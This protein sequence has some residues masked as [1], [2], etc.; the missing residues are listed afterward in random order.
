MAEDLPLKS[1]G[2]AAWPPWG[3]SK[4]HH[5]RHCRKSPCVFDGLC[6][7]KRVVLMGWPRR[8]GPRV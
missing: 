3:T 1:R 7:Y 2:D 5:A 4:V 8:K 6:V